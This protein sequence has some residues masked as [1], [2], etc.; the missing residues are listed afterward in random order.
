MDS[1][2]VS[3]VWFIMYVVHVGGSSCVAH[4]GCGS[5]CVVHHVGGSSCMCFMCVILF[6]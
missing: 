5:S 6:L 1:E 3:C 4:H 2:C